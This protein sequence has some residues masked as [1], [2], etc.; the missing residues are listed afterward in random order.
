[1]HS[2]SVLVAQTVEM[3]ESDKSITIARIS[4]RCSKRAREFAVATGKAHAYAVRMQD[5]TFVK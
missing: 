5:E 1:M 2:K 3:M 4:E